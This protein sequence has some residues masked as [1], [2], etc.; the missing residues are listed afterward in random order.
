MTEAGIAGKLM[1]PRHFLQA[2]TK[3]SKV[4]K[5]HNQGLGFPFSPVPRKTN[6]GTLLSISVSCIISIPLSSL[7]RV[8]FSFFPII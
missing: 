6:L 1:A 3:S 2:E 5:I 4:F 8:V 7:L